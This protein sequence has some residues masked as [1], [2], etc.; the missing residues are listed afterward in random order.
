[1]RAHATSESK[2][3]NRACYFS[4]PQKLQSKFVIPIASSLQRALLFASTS[5]G[6]HQ[7]LYLQRQRRRKGSRT[8][9]VK[10]QT[11]NLASLQIPAAPASPQQAPRQR[12]P[13]LPSHR[14]TKYYVLTESAQRTPGVLLYQLCLA[15]GLVARPAP[16]RATPITSTRCGLESGIWILMVTGKVQYLT[17]CLNRLAR[18]SSPGGHSFPHCPP[19]SWAAWDR[20][21]SCVQRDFGLSP[22]G[23]LR[24]P[25]LETAPMCLPSTPIFRYYALNMVHVCSSGSPCRPLV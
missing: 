1:M 10:L 2:V 12:H 15:P 25:R 14:A 9:E 11:W 23:L 17:G 7:I 22:N 21:A 6:P 16:P 5:V 13:L 8:S 3:P 24:L 18:P 4:E 20:H 19:Q